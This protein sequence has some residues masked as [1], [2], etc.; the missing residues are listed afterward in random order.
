[1]IPPCQDAYEF[2]TGAGACDWI[3]GE[4]MGEAVEKRDMMS[5]LAVCGLDEAEVGVGVRK[6]RSN[7]LDCCCC[8]CCF[9]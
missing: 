3:G 4:I 2:C 9:C 1:M 5:A 7:M 8:C 6:S